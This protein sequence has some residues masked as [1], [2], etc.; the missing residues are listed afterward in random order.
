MPKEKAET[1][2]FWDRYIEVLTEAGVPEKSRRWYVIRIERYLAAHTDQVVRDHQESTVREYLEH[3][4]RVPELHGWLFRQLIHALQLLFTQHLQISWANK[5][6]WQY[7]LA[8]SR[9]LETSHATVAR[10]NTPLKATTAQLL[11][12]DKAPDSE[13]FQCQPISDLIAEIRRRNYSIRTEEA[14]SAW[15]RRF[16]RFYQDRDPRKLGAA[17]VAAYLS[18]LALSREVA[19]STQSQALNAL[20]FFY[21][22]VLS[23]KLGEMTGLVAAKKPRRVPTVLTRKTGDRESGGWEMRRVKT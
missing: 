13:T 5:F 18:D 19:P 8:S 15:V 3:A 16:I 4:G 21:E 6:D 23:I 9:E 12:G 2:A 14:Y 7:W 10:Y 22:H 20:V 1:Q 11:P 17:E